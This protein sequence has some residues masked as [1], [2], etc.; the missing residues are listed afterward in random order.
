M[1]YTCYPHLDS[2]I[3]F[4]GTSISVYSK[5]SYDHTNNTQYYLEYWMWGS[6]MFVFI[7]FFVFLVFTF[8]SFRVFYSPSFRNFVNVSILIV[9][10]S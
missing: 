6:M 5:N 7:S 9:I 10:L 8:S 4:T 1:K 2:Y 3:T